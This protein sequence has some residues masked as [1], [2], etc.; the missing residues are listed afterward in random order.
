M[1][2]TNHMSST[3]HV[4]STPHISPAHQDPSRAQC[5]IVCLAYSCQRGTVDSLINSLRNWLVYLLIHWIIHLCSHWRIQSTRAHRTCV[6]RF[7]VGPLQTASW[8]VLEWG[9]TIAT[10][11]EPPQQKLHGEYCKALSYYIS[12]IQTNVAHQSHVIYPS[13]A[14]YSSHI[15]CAS[16][17]LA[18]TVSYSLA[19]VLLPTGC[20]WFNNWFTT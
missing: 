15:T 16:R 17:S 10:R 7:K 12:L 19:S 1:S 9:E 18:G 2:P 5:R 8:A 4:P 14:I 6:R 13:Y 11:Q 3:H 20:Y